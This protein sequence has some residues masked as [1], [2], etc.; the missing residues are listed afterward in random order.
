MK[1]PIFP[2]IINLFVLYVGVFI[3]LVIV[4]FAKQQSFT[5]KVGNFIISGRYGGQASGAEASPGNER[6]LEGEASIL[7]GGMEFFLTNDDD[8]DNLCLLTEDGQRKQTRPVS[9]TVSQGSALFL[10]DGGAQIRFNNQ[11]TGDAQGLAISIN[12][13]E[14]YQGLE[15]PYRPLRSSRIRHNNHGESYIIADGKSYLF[16]NST[17]DTTRRLILMDLTNP[18]AFYGAVPGTEA[19]DLSHLILSDARDK[20]YYDEAL[21]Q[22]RARSFSQWRDAIGANRDEDTVLAYLTESIPR[23]IYQ[24]SVSAIPSAF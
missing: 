19:L 12:L 15:L 13:P 4:Q 2:R 23:G 20:R 11:L 18:L 21:S 8:D 7:Y 9:L 22:W 3:V 16:N 24:S 5:Q 1:K 14:G 10:L 17:V 6:L